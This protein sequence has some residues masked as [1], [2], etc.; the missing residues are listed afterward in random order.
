M[1]QTYISAVR[2]FDRNVHRFLVAAAL[3]GLGFFGIYSLLLNLYL[4]RLGYTGEFI[5]MVNAVGPMAMALGSLPAAAVGR[6]YGNRL[7]MTLGYLFTALGLAGVTFNGMAP[8]PWQS[9]WILTSYAL[10]W[11][12]AS[13]VV[14]NL[15]PFLMKTTSLE[16][17]S[18]A[19]SLQNVIFPVFGFAGN[20]V[21][22]VLPGL[23]ALALGMTLDSAAPYRLSLLVA[24]ALILLAAV[25]ASRIVEQPDPVDPHT[26]SGSPQSTLPLIVI[27][28]VACIWMLRLGS[29]WTMRVFLNVYLDD[30]LATPTALIGLLS[31]GGQLM[32]LTALVAPAAIARFGN[33]RTIIGALFGMGLAFAPL[34][35]IPHWSAAGFG[36]M[37]MISFVAVS[38]PAYSIFSMEI[39]EP[40][41]RTT[42]SGAMTLALGLGIAV[43]ALGGGYIIVHFSYTLLFALGALLAIS[44]AVIFRGYFRNSASV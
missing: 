27:L 32:G 33:Q 38:G 7:A 43:V 15:A 9:A 1:I 21:G 40:Q 16:E 30:A 36:F 34:L 13:L 6:R 29:E 35:L 31:A 11:G 25:S 4:L 17:R 44:A 14:V 41:W 37:L 42:I 8:P 22:G 24:S 20:L 12:A 2:H 26:S 23:F 10:G 39:V 28:V 18:Y 3:Q 19:F 5:G